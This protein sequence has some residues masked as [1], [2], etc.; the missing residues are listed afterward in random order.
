[1]TAAER[2]NPAA[3]PFGHRAGRRRDIVTPEGVTL[4]FELADL[5][6]R[7]TA[8]A[9]DLF[10]WLLAT[11]GVY[12]IVV[13]ALVG[14]I[15]VK[16]GVGYAAALAIIL[17]TA[18]LVRNLYFIH[19]ELAWQGATPGKRIVG[20]RVVDRHGGPL[21]PMAIVARNLTREFEAFMP[22]G[23][24]MSVGRATESWE[25]LALLAWM[26]LF[27]ALPLFNRDRMRAGDMIGGT[28]VVRMPRRV[29]L[30]DLIEERARY[31]FQDRQ[32]GA[33]GAFELQV[34]EDMLRRPDAPGA[35]E[36]RLEV[37]RKIA[38]KIGWPDEIAAVDAGRFLADFYAAQRGYLEREQLYGRPRAD[39]NAAA[40][41][42][43]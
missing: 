23:I 31:M 27:T 18:F 37:A 19:F 38:A 28:I 39:K 24:L 9:I 15:L 41:T 40:G 34:L 1:M 29:L 22:L 30:P 14:T 5:G 17:L 33:Y 25:R 16:S 7:A 4:P 11:V 12:L 42:T 6:D 35:G 36:L 32:L 21:L 8:F 10:F 43:I 2:G 3:S 20:I 13:V 26:L